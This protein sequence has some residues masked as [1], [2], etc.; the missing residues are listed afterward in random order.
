MVRW[1]VEPEKGNVS[2]GFLGGS[3][4][5]S[6]PSVRFQVLH[7]SIWKAK[8]IGVAADQ[9]VMVAQEFVICI[10]DFQVFERDSVKNFHAILHVVLEVDDLW[11]VENFQGNIIL[12]IDSPTSSSMGKQHGNV[13][14]SWWLFPMTGCPAEIEQHGIITLV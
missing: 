14:L 2:L 7:W 3:Q 4:R 6:H 1:S 9:R 13:G 5:R 11:I 8:L 12:G 10:S